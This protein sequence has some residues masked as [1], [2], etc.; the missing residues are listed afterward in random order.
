MIF[1]PLAEIVNDP[2]AERHKAW[3]D[4]LVET[5]RWYQPDLK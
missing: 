5:S 4:V 1:G 3:N 2:T